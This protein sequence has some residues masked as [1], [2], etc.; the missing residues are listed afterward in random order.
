[1]ANLDITQFFSPLFQQKPDGE[2]GEV[3]EAAIRVFT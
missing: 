2:D 1:M 3:G